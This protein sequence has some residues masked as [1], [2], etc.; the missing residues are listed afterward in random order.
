MKKLIQHVLAF[1]AAALIGFSGLCPQTAFAEEKDTVVVIDGEKTNGTV[2]SSDEEDFVPPTEFDVGDFENEYHPDSIPVTVTAKKVLN[3]RPL[4]KGEF[5]FV[6]LDSDGKEVARAV[7]EEDGQITFPALTFDQ[8][9]EYMYTMKELSDKNPGGITF[10]QTVIPVRIQIRT[11]NGKFVADVLNYGKSSEAELKENDIW[12]GFDGK[13]YARHDGKTFEVKPGE[14]FTV[15]DGTK[16]IARYKNVSGVLYAG[17]LA[18]NGKANGWD[19]VS[20]EEDFV[21]HKDAV[22]TNTYQSKPAELTLTA[23]KVLENGT[24]KKG[25]YS[26]VLKDEKGKVLQTVKNDADGKITFASIKYDK[27]GTYK[28]TI[29]EVNGKDTSVTYDSNVYSVTVTVTDDLKG[30]LVAVS[31]QKDLVFTNK[32][33]ASDTSVK[34]TA[35]KTFQNGTLS[36]NDFSFVLTD[37]SGKELE[38]AKNDKNG[39]ISFKSITYTKEGTYKYAIKEA[40]GN[41]SSITYDSSAKSVTVTVSKKDGKLVAAVTGNNPTFTNTKKETTEQVQTTSVPAPSTV[42]AVIVATKQYNGGTL[43]GNDFQFELVDQNGNVLQTKTNDASGQISFDPITYDKVGDYSYNIREFAGTEK[44]VT[45]DSSIHTVGVSVKEQNGTL[46]ADILQNN[47]TFTN[48]Y[49]DLTEDSGHTGDSSRLLA[50]ICVLGITICTAVL[51]IFLI[52]KE[53]KR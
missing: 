31:D 5:T 21:E 11:V 53:N 49:Q 36:G 32:I 50:T 34:I 24:L 16:V 2:E 25:D 38:T 40:K 15:S 4:K 9:G 19:E 17:V 12:Y 14:D 42:Q 35:K 27:P 20:S 44:G 41:D 18:D 10:D 37:D 43:K 6:L 47:P 28:Y 33:N 39:A 3:G 51:T 23:K 46:T 52:R 13:I 22:F 48:T 45:Y 1:A 29:S 7:N 26:F 30:S 8:A